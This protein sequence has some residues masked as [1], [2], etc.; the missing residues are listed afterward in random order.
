[1][2]TP[3]TPNFDTLPFLVVH[4]GWFWIVLMF[5][6][7]LAFTG[8]VALARYVIAAHRARGVIALQRAAVVSTLSPGKAVLEGRWRQGSIVVGDETVELGDGP[9]IIL[10]SRR[11]SVDEDARVFVSGELGHVPSQRAESS[12]YRENAG[13]W[14]IDGAEVHAIKPRVRAEPL[15][16]AV[17]LVGVGLAFVFSYA[18]LRIVGTQ[19]KDRLSSRSPQGTGRPLELRELSAVS[20]AAALPGSRDRALEVLE[21]NL[22]EHPYRDDESVRRQLALDHIIHG[23]C[24]SLPLLR[25]MPEQQ[26]AVARRC[27][28]DRAAFDLLAER[29]DYE[30]AWRSR[31]AGLDW[32]DR[33]GMV[34]IA[35]GAW[36]T[37]AE[38][39]G[40]LASFYEHEH[41]RSRDD[42]AREIARTRALKYRCLAEWFQS[43]AGDPAASERLRQLASGDDAAQFCAAMVAQ[44]IPMQERAGYLRDVL[45]LA[46]TQDSLMYRSAVRLNEL[47]LW[48]LGGI[49]FRGTDPL[50]LV[51]ALENGEMDVRGWLLPFGTSTWQSSDPRQYLVALQG[52]VFREVQRGDFSEARRAALDAITAARDLGEVEQE[53]ARSLVT[54]V[55]LRAGDRELP[56]GRADDLE[57]DA[58]KVRRRQSPRLGMFGYPESCEQQLKRALVAAQRGDGRPLA[59]A[60][61]SCKVFATS[62]LRVLIGVLPLVDQ[63]RTELASALRW[64]VDGFGG[65]SYEPFSTI[66]YASARRD[67]ARFVGDAEAAERWAEVATR[68]LAP[69]EDETRALALVIWS[70]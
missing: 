20:I 46:P 34:A 23:D 2:H 8:S 39:A 54:L 13:V 57:S 3:L 53:A 49:R 9:R 15:P 5:S 41:E 50:F 7:A 32:P 59:K 61:Q 18:T 55:A 65:G 58:L 36:A 44:T 69:L 47:L 25:A 6:L 33:E 40:K 11:G 17:R 67:I 56:T 63:G 1:M 48:R 38:D 12:S 52:V 45:A 43:L 19:L 42:I 4:G 62:A 21:G 29:G 31:P 27:H 64:W 26:L 10:G 28:Y 66:A 24:G 35:T 16:W 37:A 30:A 14:R 70:D 60:M 68:S 51:T 22:D